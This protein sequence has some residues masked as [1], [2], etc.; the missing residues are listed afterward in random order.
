MLWHK[1]PNPTKILSSRI[2]ILSETPELGVVNIQTDEGPVRL[3]IDE[4]RAHQLM[5][6]CLKLLGFPAAM[7]MEP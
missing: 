2:D 6:E 4:Q 5:E 3:L 1:K 7:D